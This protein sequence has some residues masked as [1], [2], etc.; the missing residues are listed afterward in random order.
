MQIKK[1]TIQF[2]PVQVHRYGAAQLGVH[3]CPEHSQREGLCDIIVRTGFQTGDF[4]QFQVVGCQQNGGRNVAILPPF[5][6][7]FQ[8]AA[9]RQVDVKDQ[10]VK[11]RAAQMIGRLETCAAMC[12]G[13]PRRF[14]R[15]TDTAPPR[16]IIF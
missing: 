3:P 6:Q 5:P 13:T 4:I 9:V 2:D 1:E 11:N 7:Q 8:P 15:H 16:R 12:D 10:Q 14:K